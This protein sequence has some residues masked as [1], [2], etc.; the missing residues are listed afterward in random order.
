MESS[1][2]SGE[3][4]IEAAVYFHDML[5][6]FRVGKGTGTASLKVKFLH[7]LTEMREDILYE[8]LLDLRKTYDALDWEHCTKSW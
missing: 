7:H 8:V 6:G 1:V 2:G 4:W 5:H 3:C